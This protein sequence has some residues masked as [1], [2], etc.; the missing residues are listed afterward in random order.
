[1][2]DGYFDPWELPAIFYTLKSFKFDLQ[3]KHMKTF[4]NKT[5][6]VTV[7][8]KAGACKN[9]A[10]NKRT[11]QI[12]GFCEQFYICI[13]ASHIPGKE[14]FE[15][16]FESRIEYKDVEWMLNPKIFNEAQKILFFQPQID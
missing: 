4:S 15:A 5:T 1:M 13:T 12:W 2:S 8:N 9:H 7:I 6:A 10:L 14:N 16:D 3:G 11:Q